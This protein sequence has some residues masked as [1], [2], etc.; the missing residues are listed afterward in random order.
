[1]IRRSTTYGTAVIEYTLRRSVRRTLSISVDAEGRPSRAE[2]G[3]CEPGICG[4]LLPRR[5][6]AGASGSHGNRERGRDA[7]D[8]DCGR[9]GGSQLFVVAEGSAG[10]GGYECGTG[11]PWGYDLR[12]QGEGRSAGDG[13]GGEEGA[14]GD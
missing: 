8:D 13:A 14:G 7:V 11:A 4:T 2:C 5:E 12:G 3:R 1:M 9:G 6:P 10:G